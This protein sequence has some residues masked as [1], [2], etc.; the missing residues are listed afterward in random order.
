MRNLCLVFTFAF[1]A[2][3]GNK[4]DSGV[5]DAAKAPVRATTVGS[6]HLSVPAGWTDVPVTSSM[7]KGHFKAG[8]GTELIIYHFGAGGAGGVDKNLD[9]WYGQFKQADGKATKDVALRTTTKTADGKDAIVVDVSGHYVAAM[10]PGSAE[11]HDKKEHRML[12]A[13][14]PSGDGPYYFKFLGPKAAI[15]REKNGFVAAIASIK[16]SAP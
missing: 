16:S 7:R 15:E 14:V 9:R 10:Q 13:I 6:L 11:S 12:A 1:V 5:A 2:C 8:E 4:K 3:N